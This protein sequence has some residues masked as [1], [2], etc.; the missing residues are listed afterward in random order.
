MDYDYIEGKGDYI[1]FLHGWGGDKNSFKICQ[2]SLEN[3]MVFVSFSGFGKSCPPPYAYSVE[4][5][6]NELKELIS[7]ICGNQKPIIIC[8]SFGAR[9]AAKLIAENAGIAKKLIIVDGAGVKPKR[10]IKYHLLVMRYKRLKKKVAHG[11]ADKKLLD[12]YGSSDYKVLSGVMQKT[13][14]K[15]VNED[16]KKC[17][18]KIDCETLLIWGDKDEDTP[19]YMAK[20]INRWIKSSALVVINDAGHFSYINNF[21]M[22]ISLVRAFV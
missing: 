7:D 3:P 2:H 14:V 5:Y 12:A 8:H 11:K 20:K 13:F 15:V 4:D 6:A 19:L 21:P 16:L 22:F 18:K 17:F 1:F 9:V 10:S